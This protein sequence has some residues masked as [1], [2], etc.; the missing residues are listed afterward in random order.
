MAAGPQRRTAE[1]CAAILLDSFRCQFSSSFLCSSWSLPLLIPGDNFLIFVERD[2]NPCQASLIVITQ[3]CEHH[4]TALECAR[5]RHL[6][7]IGINE[8]PYAQNGHRL[9]G[10]EVKR[11]ISRRK[12]GKD[13]KL[14]DYLTKKT[15]IYLFR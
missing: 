3:E 10:Y 4:D 5:A 8:I 14:D 9:L 6:F 12:V 7:S 13:S 1:N 2:S 11:T 15:L